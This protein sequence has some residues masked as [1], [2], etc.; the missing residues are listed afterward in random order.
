MSDASD[1]ALSLAFLSDELVADQ[2]AS[3]VSRLRCEPELVRLLLDL[4]RSLGRHHLNDV[5]HQT[6]R[7]SALCKLVVWNRAPAG[8]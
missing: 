8:A 5:D 4:A 2:F 7:T 6:P 3:F 1:H